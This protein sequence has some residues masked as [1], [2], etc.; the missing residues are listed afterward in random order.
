MLEPRGEAVHRN[1]HDLEVDL[2]RTGRDPEADAARMARREPR[3]L[4]GDERGRS[5]RQEQ[6]AGRGPAARH[7]V[8][9]EPGELERVRQVSGE[10]AVMLAGH[11]TVEAVLDRE[12][13]L[14]AQLGDG[15]GRVELL[16]R[17]AP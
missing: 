15:L 3:R 14:R 4:L 16:V 12:R 8:E 17:I 2:E 11:H 9:Q 7:R 5:Q 10:P 1:A 13:G 6:R